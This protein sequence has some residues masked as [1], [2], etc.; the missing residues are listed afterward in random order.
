MKKIIMLTAAM[1]GL[2]VIDACANG[3]R[4]RVQDLEAGYWEYEGTQ[5]SRN[6]RTGFTQKALVYRDDSGNALT[7]DVSFDA[8]S[9]FIGDIAFVSKCARVNSGSSCPRYDYGII[10]RSGRFVLAPGEYNLISLNTS[11]TSPKSIYYQS[12]YMD[13]GMLFPTWAAVQSNRYRVQPLSKED[14]FPGDRMLVMK[15]DRFGY[16]DSNGQVIIPARFSAATPF[17]K[18]KAFVVDSEYGMGTLDPAGNFTPDPYTCVERSDRYDL[19]YSGGRLLN[20]QLDARYR[21]KEIYV[22]ENFAATMDLDARRPCSDDAKVGIAFSD[23]TKTDI[24]AI[25]KSIST[26]FNM[27]IVHTDADLCGAYDR[28]GKP[29]I[30]AQY[31]T[32]YPM[33]SAPYLVVQS[34]DSGLFGLYDN[35]GKLFLPPLYK[36]IIPGDSFFLLMDGN[37]RY[38]LAD[39]EGKPLTGFVYDD[40]EYVN[41]R[42]VDTPFVGGE[43]IRVRRNGKWGILARDGKEVVAA[44]YEALGVESEGLISFRQNGKWGVVRVDGTEIVKPIYNEISPFQGGRARA[45][46]GNR[47]EWIYSDYETELRYSSPRE[48]SPR[49]RTRGWY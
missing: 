33:I 17:V 13:R 36:K 32:I 43:Y 38:G 27:F 5:T 10:D 1:A 19:V 4:L 25:Y 26:M 15:D 20:Y 42:S 21:D 16:I 34:A 24:P 30:P 14:V 29:L 7:D 22:S 8:T 40:V 41:S 44:K 48:P 39:S 9:G 45:R 37:G 31:K 23:S 6:P 12:A 11:T 47:D 35:D 18:G 3:D 2:F 46:L 28:N 49:P